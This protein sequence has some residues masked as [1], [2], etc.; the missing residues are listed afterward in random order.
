MTLESG[1]ISHS[2]T[3]ITWVVIEYKGIG[4]TN[5]RNRLSKLYWHIWALHIDN[6][7]TQRKTGY[8]FENGAGVKGRFGGINEGVSEKKKEKG[9]M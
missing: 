3:W 9:I 1:K 8:K 7:N 5:I 4:Y 2:Y 6:H